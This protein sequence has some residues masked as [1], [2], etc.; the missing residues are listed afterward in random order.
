MTR[1]I[2]SL[3]FAFLAAACLFVPAAGPMPAR[4]APATPAPPD[5]FR[6]GL[7]PNI[8]PDQQ[9]ALYQPFGAYMQETLG[10][11]VELFVASDYAG[12]VEALASDKIDM[13]YFGGLTLC[14]G[15]DARR[16]VPDRDG[17][18]SRNGYTKV[19]QRDYYPRG[20]PDSDHRRHRG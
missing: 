17:D 8:A 18:R 19:L 15:R 7:I 13:A 12:V 20:Q 2:A 16:G 6:I 1:R 3:V 14:A 4:A 11:P 9:R 5:V 10:M